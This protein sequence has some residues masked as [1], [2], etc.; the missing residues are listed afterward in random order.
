MSKRSAQKVKEQARR[1][2]YLLLH[3]YL[4]LCKK[5]G[6]VHFTPILAIS[7]NPSEAIRLECEKRKINFVVVARR[8]L[9][10]AQKFMMASTTEYCVKNCKCTVIILKEESAIEAFDEL[11]AEELK[12]EKE[13]EEGRAPSVLEEVIVVPDAQGAEVYG[14]T[15]AAEKKEK[16]EETETYAIGKKRSHSA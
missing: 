2:A 12:V 6:L 11:S 10:K 15:R 14:L 4:E 8:K 13:E 3:H 9:S 1:H 16:E 5:A 7:N